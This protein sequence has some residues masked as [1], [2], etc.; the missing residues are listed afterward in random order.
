MYTTN[1]RLLTCMMTGIQVWVIPA[2]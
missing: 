1:S 2:A